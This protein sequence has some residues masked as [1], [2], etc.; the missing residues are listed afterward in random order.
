[1]VFDSNIFQGLSDAERQGLLVEMLGSREA[2]SEAFPSLDSFIR[3]LG[4]CQL[5]ELHLV[6]SRLEY[7]PGEWARLVEY[8]YQFDSIMEVSS[9]D[10]QLRLVDHLL[11][12]KGEWARL[13]N[14]AYNFEGL[15]KVVPEQVKGQMIERLL[16]QE[17]EWERLVQ[18]PHQF[19]VIVEVVPE[20]YQQQMIE[21]LL[22]REGDWERLLYSGHDFARLM[23]VPPLDSQLKLLR[24]LFQKD[25]K[26][27]LSLRLNFSLNWLQLTVKLTLQRN[28]RGNPL[29]SLL[30]CEDLEKFKNKLDELI[31]VPKLR[32]LGRLFGE[33]KRTAGSHVHEEGA[34]A[35]G[36]EAVEPCHLGRMPLEVL[37]RIGTFAVPGLANKDVNSIISAHLNRSKDES[38][39]ASS[40]ASA[41]PR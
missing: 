33:A 12:Q 41:A 6:F 34:L 31:E 27:Q 28:W 22:T 11:N 4:V 8:S 16:T 13:V 36:G 9:L 39:E 5:R 24:H 23:E 20:Q 32:I 7:M 25:D 19:F 21:Q 10:I 3:L 1:M 35:V 30:E 38:V 18:D 26:G 40:S 29:T 2:F 15:M 17:G 37:Q 14:N